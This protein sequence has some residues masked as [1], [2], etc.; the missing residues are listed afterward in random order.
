MSNHS[1][2]AIQL[3]F[4]WDSEQIALKKFF[5]T[6]NLFCTKRPL[7]ISLDYTP[8]ATDEEKHLLGLSKCTIA[9]ERSINLT[10]RE[11]LETTVNPKHPIWKH[12]TFI[13]TITK[14]LEEI[15]S[16]SSIFLQPD[17]SCTIDLLNEGE[18][19]ILDETGVLI[20]GP[21]KKIDMI[22]FDSVKGINGA[23]DEALKKSLSSFQ[24]YNPTLEAK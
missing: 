8:V 2:L 24:K 10:Y 20:E 11:M 23:V 7:Q 6:N 19:A 4:I 21:Y 18:C 14:Y 13:Y 3:H 12:E 9:D 16:A 22:H 15:N 5:E 17:I 1:F